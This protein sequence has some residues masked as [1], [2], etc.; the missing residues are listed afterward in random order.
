MISTKKYISFI[1]IISVLASWGALNE[2]ST[3]KSLA[4]SDT[5]QLNTTFPNKPSPSTEQ[6]GQSIAHSFRGLIQINHKY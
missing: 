3:N 4:A 2:Y 5:G 6:I 1:F